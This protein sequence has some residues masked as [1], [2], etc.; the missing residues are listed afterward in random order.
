[1]LKIYQR[2]AAEMVKAFIGVNALRTRVNAPVVSVTTKSLYLMK[3]EE[4]L[5][6]EM[7]RKDRFDTLQQICNNIISMALERW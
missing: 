2:A 7:T 1:M 6:W 5:G 3:E 4:K